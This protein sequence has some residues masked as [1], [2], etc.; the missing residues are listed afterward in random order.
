[1]SLQHSGQMYTTEDISCVTRLSNGL[2]DI[3]VYEKPVC[4]DL[5]LKPSSVL[6]ISQKSL[7]HIHDREFSRSEVGE[8]HV[9][10]FVATSASLALAHQGC[11]THPCSVHPSCHLSPLQPSLRRLPVSLCRCLSSPSL[12]VY[13]KQ[14]SVS[15]IEFCVL[16]NLSLLTGA[17]YIH[18]DCVIILFNCSCN[19]VLI[20]RNSHYFMG[21][22][23]SSM[24]ECLPSIWEALDST[25]D[26]TRK[27]LHI[28]LKSGNMYYIFFML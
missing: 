11:V 13:S 20:H 24:L 6:H 23:Q 16:L 18:H 1:M 2:P 4:N 17:E 22:G 19:Q 27:E 5:N 8:K 9:L 10:C 14:R 25:I 7:C 26:T 3:H 21:R 28:I 12:L 15:V